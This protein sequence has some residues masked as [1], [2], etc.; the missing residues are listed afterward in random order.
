MNFPKV[1]TFMAYA[2]SRKDEFQKIKYLFL[3]ILTNLNVVY[4]MFFTNIFNIIFSPLIL[5]GL[6]FIK[7]REST[8]HFFF[9]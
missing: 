9:P 2:A 6:C 3:T 1:S 8:I 5:F 4:E 7:Y